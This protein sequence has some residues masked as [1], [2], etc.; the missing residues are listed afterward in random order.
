VG[1]LAGAVRVEWICCLGCAMCPR[2]VSSELGQCR[3]ASLY[4]SPGHD[5]YA[6]R[7]M[8]SNH[9]CLTGYPAVAWR[10]AMS[11]GVFGR[12]KVWTCSLVAVHGGFGSGAGVVVGDG[13]GVGGA[14]SCCAGGPAMSTLQRRGL[15]GSRAP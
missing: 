3:A 13:T 7:W 9:V 4:V 12:S 10:Y 14:G 8:A 1:V 6:P 11:A 15:A 5:A 2:S